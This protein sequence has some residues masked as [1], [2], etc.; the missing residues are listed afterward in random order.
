MPL[1]LFANRTSCVGFIL[2]FIHGLVNIWAV[3]FLPVYFQGALGSS[4]EYAGIQF[5][6]TMLF[7]FV[8]VGMGGRLMAKYGRYRPISHVGFALMTLGLGL[9][10]LL[11]ANSSRAEWVIFQVV[12]VAGAGLVIP[13]LLPSVQAELT[14]ADI[15]LATSTCI[16]MRSFSS[17]WGVVIPATIFNNRFDQ[18]AGRISDPAIVD[19]LKGGKAYEHATKKFLDTLPSQVRAEVVSVFSD[20]LERNWQIATAFAAVGFLIVIGQKEVKL[21]QVLDTEYG[22]ED[23]QADKAQNELAD[24]KGTTLRQNAG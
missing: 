18:L 3:Y 14:D 13:T 2:T 8:F 5:L 12:E 20:S 15:A 9:F 24:E 11:D 7:M 16:F 10:S 17:I 1:H 4:P 19:Q 23:N 6:P 22:L 21:R